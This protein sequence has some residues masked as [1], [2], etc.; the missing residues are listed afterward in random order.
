MD[1]INKELDS[2]ENEMVETNNVDKTQESSKDKSLSHG[3]VQESAGANEGKESTDASPLDEY[4]YCKT[5]EYT[6]EMFK[7]VVKNIPNRIPFGRFR[8]QI[9]SFLGKDLKP[10]KI[11]YNPTTDYAFL[12]FTNS[13]KQQLAISKLNGREWKQNKL[14]C[15]VAAPMKDP[16]VK[17]RK[18]KMEGRN[19]SN[20]CDIKREKADDSENDIPPEE[21]ITQ[22][23]CPY[24]LKP[25]EE[26]LVLKQST[27]AKCI[28]K[29]TGDMRYQKIGGDW[30][31]S[32]SSGGLCLELL[33][34]IKSPVLNNYRN[35]VEFTIGKDSNGIENTV[36]FRIGSYV[37]GNLAIVAPTKCINCTVESIAVARE[38]QEFIRALAFTSYDCSTHKGFW[39]QVVVRTCTTGD[40]MVIVQVQPSQISGEELTDVKSKIADF[41][42]NQIK[43]VKVSSV[44]LSSSSQRNSVIDTFVHLAGNKHI[45]E[46]LLD[47]HFRIS[48]DAFFQVN[49][50]AAEV[51]YRT[52]KEWS[53]DGEMEG[54]GVLDVCCGTGTI[55][56][57][58]AHNSSLKVAGI[59]ISQQAIEDACYNADQNK[60]TNASFVCGPAEDV[61]KSVVN[62]FNTVKRIIAIVDPPRAGLRRNVIDTL[63]KCDAIKKL[64]YVSCSPNQAAENLLSLCR[65]QSKRMPG[66][67]F[68]TVRAV[69]VDLFPHTPH[70]ELIVEL[71]R[72]DDD[73]EKTKVN[74]D[75]VKTEVKVESTVQTESDTTGKTEPENMVNMEPEE[76]ITVVEPVKQGDTEMSVTPATE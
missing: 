40:V 19:G 44:Y 56:L 17:E 49:T 51:L 8:T 12:A 6:S 70:C 66:R 72:C 50:P 33:P 21:R 20:D 45:N 16:L 57:C 22:V 26:Q 5:G 13:E 63:R 42:T 55:G 62:S 9:H 31:P 41:F 3:G 37:K 38:F 25:Y 65:P 36:G 32:K 58:L 2:K 30:L 53:D 73:N 61:T 14:E 59:E 69:P 47:L 28:K 24:I 10:K 34:I 76:S 54:A 27:I 52:I 43:D 60:V 74:V 67:P 7:V 75:S 11:K 1:V 64:I 71:H 35:K 39:Q 46:K 48:P 15:K 18:R 4:H 23:V 68:R 29:L